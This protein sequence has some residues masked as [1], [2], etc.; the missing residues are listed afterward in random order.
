[1]KDTAEKLK[2][3]YDRAI[4]TMRNMAL[5]FPEG[6]DLRTIGLNEVDNLLD[7]RDLLDDMVRKAEIRAEALELV[8]QAAYMILIGGRVGIMHEDLACPHGGHSH[9]HTYGIWCDKCFI[10]LEG[11]LIGVGF[12]VSPRDLDQ[13]QI[14]A[15]WTEELQKLYEDWS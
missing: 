3:G 4:Q 15:L 14:N 2:E 1:M 6:H 13:E 12:D 8:A 11:A 5:Q 7:D 10:T 9:Q